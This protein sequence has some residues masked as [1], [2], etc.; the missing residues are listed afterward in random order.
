MWHAD[1]KAGVSGETVSNAEL[2]DFS[3]TITFFGTNFDFTWNYFAP[4]HWS[5]QFQQTTILIDQQTTIWVA[6]LLSLCDTS[7]WP[8]HHRLESPWHLCW[9]IKLLVGLAVVYCS[10][11]IL[12]A[13]P[14]IAHHSR[15]S[16]IRDVTK[17]S[18][19]RKWPSLAS[20]PPVFY[21][22]S[23]ISRLMSWLSSLLLSWLSWLLFWL[24]WLSS[25]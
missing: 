16:K 18:W 22:K 8:L 7:T 19:T 1:S 11:C 5:K 17:E 2:I 6:S 4:L 21:V 23:F 24:S 15:F 10:M 12:A 25:T 20:L 14:Q 13:K 9:Q 3:L